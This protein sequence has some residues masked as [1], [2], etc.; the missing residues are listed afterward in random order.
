M[1]KFFFCVFFL[2]SVSFL[3]A[4]DDSTGKDRFAYYFQEVK[5]AIAAKSSLWDTNFYGPILL[6][7]P[8]TRVVTANYPDAMGILQQQG[9]VFTG[10]L[11]TG[12]NIANYVIQW[13]GRRWAMIMTNLIPSQKE[14][15]INL[16]AHELFHR[17][18]DSLGIQIE[19]ADNQ[20]LDQKDGRIYLR[21][22]L[23]ALRKAIL[24]RE[25]K[26]IRSHLFHA[27]CFRMYRYRLFPQAEKSEHHLEMNEGITEYTG[28]IIDNR[29]PSE[30]RLKLARKIE[31]LQTSAV[32]F[33]RNFAYGTIPV[34]GY[35]LAQH[36]PNWNKAVRTD[37][38]LY[39]FFMLRFGIRLPTLES[40][41]IQMM[42]KAYQGDSIVQQ[43]TQ[44]EERIQI[45]KREYRSKLIQQPH[46][47]IPCTSLRFTANTGAQLSL[48]GIGTIY[49]S[50]FSATDVWG[51]LLVEKGGV[52]VYAGK[53]KLHIGPV[54]SIEGNTIKGADWVLNLKE[55]YRIQPLEGTAHFILIKL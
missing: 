53:E 46:L 29:K 41:R 13:N 16:L 24:A 37:T 4:Q 8:R 12:I 35:L 14:D 34:Y 38:L 25:K 39:R 40:S 22:E 2:Y 49:Q 51:S 9:N 20:H 11:P 5:A 43:E 48:D 50:F 26:V 55:G 42:A 44:R 33:V 15:R 19:V 1:K 6:V 47:V 45:L 30:A 27:F 21:L 28:L 10:V 7:D 54:L 31:S 18:Q 3:L 23:E 36:Q 52:L 17:V 32:S